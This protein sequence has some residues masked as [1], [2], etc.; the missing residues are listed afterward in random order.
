MVFPGERIFLVLGVALCLYFLIRAIRERKAHPL[1]VL[2]IYAVAHYGFIVALIQFDW[3][4]YY[5]PTFLSMKLVAA[6]GAV[7]PFLLLIY[8]WKSRG[9]PTE[10]ID[11]A[12]ATEQRE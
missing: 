3:R 11:A 7:A 1:G 8:F 6:V 4:R 12:Q 10:A 9:D 5:I 2:L